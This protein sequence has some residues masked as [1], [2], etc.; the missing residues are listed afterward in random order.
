MLVVLQ[1]HCTHQTLDRGGGGED[2]HH[3]GAA[4]DFVV[5]ALEQV[6]AADFFAVLGGEV[7]ER[8]HR[9]AGRGHQLSRPGELG[10]EHGAHLIPLLQHRFFAL[11]REH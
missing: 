2:N 11:L 10:G 8:Q 9:L 6:G 3:A 4:L 5:D 1:Q 7:A